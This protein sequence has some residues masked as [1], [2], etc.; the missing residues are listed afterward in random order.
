MGLPLLYCCFRGR[1]AVTRGPLPVSVLQSFFA[2]FLI[3][4][5]VLIPLLTVVLTSYP[6]AVF[7]PGSVFTVAAFPLPI[8]LILVFSFFMFFAISVLDFVLTSASVI[9]QIVPVSIFLFKCAGLLFGFELIFWLRIILPTLVLRVSSSGSPILVAS[10][11]RCT[12]FGVPRLRP[13]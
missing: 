2:P 12:V 1:L 5:L 4:A 3:A 10:I 9:R 7:V 8:S 11:M 6:V 13:S